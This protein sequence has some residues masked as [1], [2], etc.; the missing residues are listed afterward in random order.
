[1]AE[2]DHSILPPPSP[3]HRRIAAGQFDRANQVIATGNHD[4]GI[5]LLLSCCKFDPANLIYRQALR[6]TQ[7][8]KYRNNMRGSR[9]AWLTTIWTRGKIKK[10]KSDREYLMVLELGEQVLMR[11]PWDVGVQMD[12]AEA[13]ETL[14]LLDLAIWMLEQAR[15]KAPQDLHV[16]RALARLYERRGNFAQAIALWELVK[17]AHPHDPEAMTKAKDLAANETI[18]RGQYEA[19]VG[20]TPAPTKR[21]ARSESDTHKPVRQREARKQTAAPEHSTNEAP[22]RET[23]P[24][25]ERVAREAAPLLARLHADP[26]NPNPYLQLAAHY[27]KANP[28]EQARTVL[29]QGL[30]PTGNSFEISTELADLEIEPFRQ[31]LLL[32]EEKLRSDEEDPELRKIRIRLLKEINTRELELYRLKSDRYPADMTYRF[33]L[34]V[35]L[36]RA[37]QVDEAIK[38]LQATRSDPRHQWRALLWLGHC[39]KTRNNWRLARRNFEEALHLLPLTEDAVRKDVLFQLASGSA[40]TGDLQHAVDVAHELANLDFAYREIGRLLD[41]WQQ[42]LEQAKATEPNR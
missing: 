21:E 17:K 18:V 30:A 15:Q 10:A 2:P 5:R 28:W 36:L 31:N 12:M 35:R 4:Y 39:F 3:E 26:T 40:E 37:G 8:L 27:R 23:T 29:Q 16:N 1:M 11:N 22:A 25:E 34:G 41:E 19:A 24:A 9:L 13:A 14:G 32:T 42:R 20:T 38:E 7:K 6:R 33:E